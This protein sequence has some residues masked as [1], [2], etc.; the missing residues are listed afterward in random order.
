MKNIDFICNEL[1]DLPGVE[2]GIIYQHAVEDS[3]PIAPFCYIRFDPAYVMIDGPGLITMM[4]KGDPVVHAIYEPTF[5]LDNCQGMVTLNPEYLQPGEVEIAVE[6]V[7][8]VLAA[9]RIS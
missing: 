2:T 3:E 9:V 5:M 1:K 4:K 8:Q 6:K 7:K